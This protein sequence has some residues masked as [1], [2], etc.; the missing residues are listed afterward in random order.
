MA[1]HTTLLTGAI[2]LGAGRS[3][4][5]GRDKLL[6]PLLG[7][8]LI[9]WSLQAFQDCPEMGEIVLVAS[10]ENEGTMERI[11]AGFPKVVRVCLGGER[12]QDSVRAAL[13][14]VRGWGWVAI[15]DGAR[16]GLTPGLV[17]LA[18]QAAR[19]TGAAIPA[20][21]VRETVKVV[22]E[23]GVVEST[24]DRERLWLAQTPQ[25]FR[26]DIIWRAHQEFSGEAT[27]DAQMVE[28]LGHPVKVFPG[29]PDNIKVTTEEDLAVAEA[30]LRRRDALQSG[31]RL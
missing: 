26:W 31:H 23:G 8:P 15:H 3:L 21:P 30:L 17:H 16:P 7:Q 4:R 13:E 18:L 19:E 1:T 10:Q 27:D 20:L 2:V 25:V 6:L 28:A 5:L 9:A 11:A 22:G 29:A 12:R 14:V 24:P